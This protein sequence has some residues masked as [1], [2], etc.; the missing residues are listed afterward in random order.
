MVVARRELL[1]A[2]LVRI[3]GLRIVQMAGCRFPGSGA[4]GLVV[5]LV[6]LAQ[7]P[8]RLA[9]SQGNGRIVDETISAGISGW[10][11]AGR[12]PA[13]RGPGSAGARRLLAG[14]LGPDTGGA[15]GLG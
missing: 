5:W 14:C 15:V 3:R 1:P 11:N 9:A 12:R 8:V 13:G 2:D 4:L 10:C 7:Y 6:R